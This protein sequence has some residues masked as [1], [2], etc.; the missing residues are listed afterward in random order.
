VIAPW[1]APDIGCDAILAQST[2]TD[3]GHQK[4]L[5]ELFYWQCKR[6]EFDLD[7]SK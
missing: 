7:S 4:L 2:I 5:R 3:R 1:I 6:V